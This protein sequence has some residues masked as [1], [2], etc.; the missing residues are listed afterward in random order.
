MPPAKRM[1][2]VVELE[3]VRSFGIAAT[4]AV[5]AATAPPLWRGYQW[6]SFRDDYKSGLEKLMG[7]VQ[8]EEMRRLSRLYD[9]LRRSVGSAEWGEAQRLGQEILQ[10]Y[11]DYRETA[12]LLA[13]A[14]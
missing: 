14:G 10:A 8:P 12:G 5:E 9:R 11:P 2:G 3:H 13:L 7:R 4:A 1:G 6:I